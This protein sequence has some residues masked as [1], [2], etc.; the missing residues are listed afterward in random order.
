MLGASA[1]KRGLEEVRFSQA[2]E[3]KGVFHRKSRE[4]FGRR[5]SLD[6]TKDGLSNAVGME[7]LERERRGPKLWYERDE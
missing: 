7:W 2:M 5:Y 4:K 3:R 1:R 6:E